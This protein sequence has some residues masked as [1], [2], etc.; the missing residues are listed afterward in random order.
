MGGQRLQMLR[1][2]SPADAASHRCGSRQRAVEM[3]IRPP[4]RMTATSRA[5]A[6][7]SMLPR[8]RK[9]SRRR[10]SAPA[11]CGSST[12]IR[13]APNADHSANGASNRRSS[14]CSSLKEPNSG[15]RPRRVRISPSCAVMMSMTRPNRAFC[16]KSSPFSASRCASPSGSP[17]ARRFVF[18]LLQLYA[19]KVRSPILFAASKARRTKSRPVRMCLVQGMTRFP[20]DM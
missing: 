11:A 13:E 4:Q 17:V 8:W 16:A 5:A 10:R 7:P 2:R 3:D 6:A 14:N 19:A 18:R 15:V 1:A 12:S 20:K 9:H